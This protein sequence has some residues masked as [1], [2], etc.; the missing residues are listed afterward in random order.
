MRWI[1]EGERGIALIDGCALSEIS[2]F[3]QRLA[4]LKF[5]PAGKSIFRLFTADDFERMHFPA[6]LTAASRAILNGRGRKHT[7]PATIEIASDSAV[8]DLGSVTI[9]RINLGLA[10]SSSTAFLIEP[11]CILVGDQSLGFYRGRDA[12]APGAA[13]ELAKSSDVLRELAKMP[14]MAL[15]L[16]WAGALTGGLAPQ[17]L[18]AV[19]QITIEIF[20]EFKSQMARYANSACVAAPGLAIS[21]IT[22]SE[23]RE[24]LL[25]KL[26][27]DLKS[28]LYSIP[29][30]FIAQPTLRY[31]QSLALACNAI[32]TR[33]NLESD[34]ALDID[35]QLKV[36]P[37][38]E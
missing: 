3:E 37:T 23:Q 20:E 13:F 31:K 22:S 8:L 36:T 7:P 18:N 10:H 24:A 14:L 27:A 5:N 19:S 38:K 9:K 34:S 4:R 6:E 11:D 26:T 33:L 35:H 15:G 25:S 2:N 30:D 16:P 1:V 29:A 21:G 28:Q 32:M 12:P 17:H